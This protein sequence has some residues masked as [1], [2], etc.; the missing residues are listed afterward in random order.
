MRLRLTIRNRFAPRAGRARPGPQK[1]EAAPL[2]SMLKTSSTK[3]AG[4]RKGVVGVGGGGRNRAGPVGKH[5]VD[6]D[7]GV[8][9]S[10]NFIQS[11]MV[12]ST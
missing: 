7:E 1:P 3:S 11:F 10:D 8:G 2:T 4:P 9:R 6:G 12:I 5:K